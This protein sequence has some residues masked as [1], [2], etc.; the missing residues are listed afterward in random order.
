[1]SGM[2]GLNVAA[3]AEDDTFLHSSVLTSVS[4]KQSISAHRS[5]DTLKHPT[6]NPTS[7]SSQ[8]ACWKAD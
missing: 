1:M 8:F 6:S 2:S 7:S 5:S 4:Q 3:V